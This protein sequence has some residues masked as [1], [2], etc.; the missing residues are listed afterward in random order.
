MTLRVHSFRSSFLQKLREWERGRKR[1]RETERERECVYVCLRES[2]C[3]ER[4]RNKKDRMC[5]YNFFYVCYFRSFWSFWSFPPS[6]HLMSYRHLSW[7]NHAP[8]YLTDHAI[9]QIY[10]YTHYYDPENTYTQTHTHKH[11]LEKRVWV[12]SVWKSKIDKARGNS[13]DFALK[14]CWTMLPHAIFNCV[15]NIVLWK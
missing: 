5:V 9:I 15:Y 12:V 6:L 4:Q 13:Y 11:T 2:V 3:Y 8:F 7:L 10:F 14:F 1:V